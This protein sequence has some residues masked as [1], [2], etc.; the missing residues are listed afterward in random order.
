MP[1]ITYYN[2]DKRPG[3][4]SIEEL[5]ST[6][7]MHL[8]KEISYKD[9]FLDTNRSR[10]MNIFYAGKYSSDVNHITGDINYIAL[11]LKPHN[12]VL[13]IH[14]FGYFE[15]PVHHPFTKFIYKLF[16]L[17]L[18][19]R[20]V[21]YITTVSFFSKN[22]IL[23][24]FPFLEKKIRVIYNPVDEKFL[25]I[26]KVINKEK[27]TIL[28][29]GTGD[30]KNF[31]RLIAAVRNIPCK[32]CFIGKLNELLLQQLKEQGTEYENYFNISR[33]EVIEKYIT[34]DILFF[35]SL[36]EGFGMPIIEA[37]AVGRPVITSNCASMPETAGEAALI[38]DPYSVQDIREAI[39]VLVKDDLKREE[40]ILKGFENCKRFAIGKIV[41]D[42][43]SLYKE[44]AHKK[45]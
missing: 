25:P 39:L 10:V 21:D 32:I 37:N 2:R 6:I 43:I 35:A 41:N 16:W 15:N 26:P 11:G 7:K 31:H 3:N 1:R 4:F 17:T 27:P 13:T 44:I 19:L 12:T 24:Y 33:E 5:F 38:V 23:Q 28:A 45:T 8:P 34:S 20:R 30:H 9:F 14:D 18:P 40:L 36:Y 29:I 22:K 42:Y